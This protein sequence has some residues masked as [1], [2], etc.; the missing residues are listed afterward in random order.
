[1]GNCT[2]ILAQINKFNLHCKHKKASCKTLV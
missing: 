2:N 1:L